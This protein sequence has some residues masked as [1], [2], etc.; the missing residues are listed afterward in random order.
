MAQKNEKDKTERINVGRRAFLTGRPGAGVGHLCRVGRKLS[1]RLQG[2]APGALLET[3][4]RSLL[5]GP[6]DQRVGNT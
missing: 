3:V 1:P 4:A 2:P 6:L 5:N